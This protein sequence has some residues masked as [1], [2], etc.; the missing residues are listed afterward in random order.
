MMKTMMK[1]LPTFF[2]LLLFASC[3]GS[4][5][6]FNGKFRQAPKVEITDIACERLEVEI[7]A[8]YCCF[9]VDTTLVVSTSSHPEWHYSIYSINDLSLVGQVV[10]IG[11][12]PGEYPQLMLV[13]CSAPAM[14]NGHIKIWVT[15]QGIR[16]TLERIDFTR[17]LAEGRTVADSIVDVS[18]VRGQT[19]NYWQPAG[20]HLWI[21]YYTDTTGESG[22]LLYDAVSK[23][24]TQCQPLYTQCHPNRSLFFSTKSLNT[25]KTMWAG[26]ML[27]FSQINFVPLADGKFDMENAFSVSLDKR[28]TPLSEAVATLGTPQE[29]PYTYRATLPFADRFV[30]SY[31]VTDESTELHIFDDRGNLLHRLRLDC[32]LPN[33]DID[34]ASGMLYGLCSERLVRADIGRWLK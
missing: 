25:D 32:S 16:R 7:P 14:E 29:S 24:I 21:N 4:D 30:A 19:S 34:P 15:N 28:A 3:N 26:G 8:G 9:V 12:G 22:L 1:S 17:S 31:H 27:N 10:R 33:F 5:N 13:A 6:I 11:N 23:E 2:A 18:G 20:D